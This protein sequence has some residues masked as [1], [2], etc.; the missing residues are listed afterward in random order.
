[1]SQ[2]TISTLAFT[3]SFR[4][5]TETEATTTT[6]TSTS[7]LY[8]ST[9]TSEIISPTASDSTTTTT[10]DSTATP[11]T[12]ST[13]SEPYTPLSSST[14]TTTT[15]S[16]STTTSYS[17]TTSWTYTLP[18]TIP[19][20]PTPSNDSDA[21][22]T[23]A[24][25]AIVVASVVGIVALVLSTFLIVR[26]RR[27][28]SVY[29]QNTPPMQETR[30]NNYGGVGGGGGGG[31]VNNNTNGAGL[32]IT[33]SNTN[34]PYGGN[35]HGMSHD[36]MNA[37]PLGNGG[38]FSSQS[39]GF[40]YDNGVIPGT[41]LGAGMYGYD[42]DYHY[43][44]QAVHQHTTQQPFYPL[45]NNQP[46][47]YTPPTEPDIAPE[48]RYNPAYGSRREQEAAYMDSQQQQLYLQSQQQLQQQ[49]Q[50]QHQQQQQRQRQQQYLAGQLPMSEPVIPP[51]TNETFDTRPTGIG[52]GSQERYCPDNRFSVNSQTYL[53]QLRQSYPP[54][55][56]DQELMGIP[57][58]DGSAGND[59]INNNGRT[60]SPGLVF[61]PL[62]A[63]VP[64][65]LISSHVGAGS[66]GNMMGSE[67]YAYPESD[68]RRVLPN[69]R[70]P[71]SS[72]PISSSTVVTPAVTVQAD[73]QDRGQHVVDND[74]T[75]VANSTQGELT[76]PQRFTEGERGSAT[77][78]NSNNSDNVGSPKR[79][80]VLSQ[81]SSTASN[82][83][84]TK[85][86]NSPQ[87]IPS[88]NSLQLAPSPKRGPQMRDPEEEPTVTVIRKP[89]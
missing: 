43:Q 47:S 20:T 69:D 86:L 48:D 35:D 77:E 46:L 88:T 23:G 13:T 76:P 84:N 29:Y 42:D 64:V 3:T 37:S 85:R 41:A 27:R 25:V 57:S 70:R 78:G 14:I 50:L 56:I 63:P 81:A 68:A 21:L 8:P 51:K 10:P 89:M 7:E 75:A 58:A 66:A 80:S 44:Q 53:E 28:N 71:S 67:D 54:A 62:P 24:I 30:T 52:D 16:S 73:V 9:S 45:N 74:A 18:T 59:I 12:S 79:S 1:M 19:P 15:A 61:P 55:T 22:S 17:T 49:Q 87:V 34:P 31:Q 36:Q 33:S 72:R 83:L 5:S 39:T 38:G 40:G 11:I 65:P 32:G 26:R 6:T 82:S 2:G 4:P 60:V